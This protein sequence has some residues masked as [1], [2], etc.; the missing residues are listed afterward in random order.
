VF[1]TSSATVYATRSDAATSWRQ[2]TGAVGRRCLRNELARE[3]AKV[4]ARVSSLRPLAFPAMAQRSAAYR[5][6]LTAETQ[7]Q[8][9]TV[10]L[11]AV[12]LMQ[13]RALA[14]V[15]VGTAFAQPDLA[16]DVKLARVVAGR[17]QKAMR[18]A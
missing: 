10:T 8:T 2:G 4:G 9:L 17:M 14:T 11:D 6:T 3:F 12:V 15:V 18:G 13:G 1:V 7:G 16:A 5:L